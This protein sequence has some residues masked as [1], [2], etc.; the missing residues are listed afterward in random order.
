MN[1]NLERLYLKFCFSESV[2]VKKTAEE[3]NVSIRTI[4][5]YIKILKKY[6]PI[7]R[8]KKGEYKLLEKPS[9][10]DKELFSLFKGL[11]FSLNLYIFKNNSNEIKKI[12]NSSKSLIVSNLEI[13]EFEINTIKALLYYIKEDFSIKIS[14]KN[15]NYTL[16]PLKIGNFDLRW[17]LFAYDLKEDRIKTFHINSIASIIPLNE[18]LLGKKIEININSKYFTSNKQKTLI[19]V[20]DEF[21]S[22][23]KKEIFKFEFYHIKELIEFVKK[24]LTMIEIVDKNLKEIVKEELLK[25]IKT[26]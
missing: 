13:E 21:K 6:Y 14:Y 11:V 5:N 3:F 15:K 2:N 17:Y 26:L 9:L 1:K 10:L 20:K 8:I 7:K 25:E 18:N 16:H 22:Y 4:Q 23:F 19:K 12:F 24:H